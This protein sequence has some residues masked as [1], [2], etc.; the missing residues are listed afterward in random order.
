MPLGLLHVFLCS[1]CSYTLKRYVI[2][3]AGL[4]TFC[5]RYPEVEDKLK[6]FE[7]DHPA[8]QE[9]KKKRIAERN[10]VVPGHLHSML[11]G[12]GL[13]IYEHLAPVEI[14][15]QFFRDRTDDL[16]A[17]ETIHFIHAIKK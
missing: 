3:G 4:D 16:T 9:Y 14:N 11:E 13:H 1:W 12:A 15:E 7:I 17:F 8:T 6:I 5:F 10:I 2:L